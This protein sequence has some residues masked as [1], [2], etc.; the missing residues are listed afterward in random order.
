MFPM[1]TIRFG[2]SDAESFAGPNI[3]PFARDAIKGRL[4]ETPAERRTSRRLGFCIA[5]SLSGRKHAGRH[6]TQK[7]PPALERPAFERPGISTAAMI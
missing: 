2:E 1:Q 3:A 4:N 7:T 6:R 5:G